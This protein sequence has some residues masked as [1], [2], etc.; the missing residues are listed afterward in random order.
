MPLSGYLAIISRWWWTIVVSAWIAGLGAF[1]IGSG[2]PPTYE[3]KARLLVGPVTAD[4]NTLKGSAGLIPTFV[5]LA[6]D[7]STL[8][9]VGAQVNETSAALLER[10]TVTGNDVTRVI[11][12]RARSHDPAEAAT[13]ANDISVQLLKLQSPGTQLPEGQ[14]TVLEPASPPT[15]PIAPDVSLLVVL[16][17]VAGAVGALVLILVVEYLSDSIRDPSEV[18]ALTQA[19]ILGTV[20]IPRRGGQEPLFVERAPESRAATALRGATVKAVYRARKDPLSSI[21]VAGTDDAPGAG[22]VAANMAAILVRMG[23]RVTL[24][25][26]NEDRPEATTLLGALD[27]PGALQMLESA[28]TAS[29]PDALE[30]VTVRRSPG[31]DT[32]PRGQ[33]A[34]QAL[35]VDAIARL[36]ELIGARSDTVIVNAAP[37][38][39][40]GSALVWAQVCEGVVLVVRSDGT[41]RERV[42]QAV[43][44]LRLVGAT[45]MGSVAINRP[46]LMSLAPRTGREEVPA[47]P[48]RPSPASA[49]SP[50]QVR[51]RPE[52]NLA[53]ASA[54]AALGGA[55]AAAGPAAA[56][57]TRAA[58]A[59]T[60]PATS[61]SSRPTPGDAATRAGGSSQA[62]SA[63]AAAAED[64]PASGTLPATAESATSSSTAATGAT[65]RTAKGPSTRAT[66][67]ASTT[68]RS[69]RSGTTK[70][71]K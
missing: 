48:P 70:R 2:L 4:V 37:V 61:A 71:S 66:K 47:P 40:S 9:T 68:R 6:T 67:P 24:V 15:D 29:N 26:A 18:A 60:P 21:L 12:I 1:V 3:A 62:D 7:G 36:L 41:K 27:H 46:S 64:S 20:R 19:P 23:R 55:P 13:I 44:G 45:I 56:A 22:E 63:P 8:R 42:L 43:E 28:E 31:F 59:I 5:E 25:D 52:G 54:T 16:A 50:V 65:K 32:V 11:S 30:L 51:P 53:P 17:S 39:R 14:L 34:G 57:T 33:K 58:A 35:P 38:H 10:V 69:S 49:R